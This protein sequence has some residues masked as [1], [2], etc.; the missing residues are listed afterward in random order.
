MNA[1]RPLAMSLGKRGTRRRGPERQGAA[2]CLGRPRER[3]DLVKR[4]PPAAYE[5]SH[6]D[7]IL[8]SGLVIGILVLAIV[9]AACGVL[10]VVAIG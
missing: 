5:V 9:G 7:R 6:C 10:T 3:G 8:R 4:T 1:R 2:V